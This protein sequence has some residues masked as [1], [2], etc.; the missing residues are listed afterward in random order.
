MGSDKIMFRGGIWTHA[1][2]ASGC[3]KQA[4]LTIRPRRNTKYDNYWL[5]ANCWWWCIAHVIDIANA[6]VLLLLYC[7][8]LPKVVHIGRVVKQGS[9][10]PPQGTNSSLKQRQANAQQ[11]SS[12][13][14]HIKAREMQSYREMQE[15][16]LGLA[17]QQTPANMLSPRGPTSI[18]SPRYYFYETSCS[19]G[20]NTWLFLALW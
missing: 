18:I 4:L 1:L 10:L 3:A 5:M 14:Q 19:T 13:H 20:Q 7:Y 2:R 11:P 15:Q 17:G 12:K 6:M 9:I 8:I 16:Q